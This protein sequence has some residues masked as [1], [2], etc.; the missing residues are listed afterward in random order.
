MD[1]TYEKK[2]E[3]YKIVGTNYNRIDGED[4][5]TGRARYT[6]DIQM[7]GMLIGKF[8]RSPYAHAR[9]LNVDTS[10]AEKLPGVKAVIT[11]RDFT[12][13]GGGDWGFFK[14]KIPPRQPSRSERHPPRDGCSFF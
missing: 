6:A 7:P 3:D 12:A 4:K 1:R 2:P 10:E 13:G 11:G 8:V 14:K 5:V 9:I